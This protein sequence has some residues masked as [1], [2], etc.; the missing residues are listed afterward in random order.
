[1]RH[2]SQCCSKELLPWCLDWWKLQEYIRVAYKLLELKCN[3]PCLGREQTACERAS[4]MHTGCR[5]AW[6]LEEGRLESEYNPLGCFCLAC[7]CKTQ[8]IKEAEILSF[9]FGRNRYSRMTAVITCWCNCTSESHFYTAM[10]PADKL[11]GH[12]PFCQ[13][14]QQI[15]SWLKSQWNS[16][17]HGSCPDIVNQIANYHHDGDQAADLKTEQ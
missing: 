13:P 4:P 3:I 2:K 17:L 16:I 9:Y 11:F 7:S 15:E 1:M 12:T 6:P 14:M 8:W 10:P 5:S